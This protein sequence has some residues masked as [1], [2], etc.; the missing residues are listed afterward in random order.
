MT[1]KKE[2]KNNKKKDSQLVIRI[3]ADERD[4]FVSLCEALD[5]S[6]SREIRRFMKRFVASNGA[7][8]GLEK[9]D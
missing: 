4:A 1:S 9:T 8:R 2:K 5:S 7:D 3:N 6:A